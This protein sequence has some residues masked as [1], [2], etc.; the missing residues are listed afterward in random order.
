MGIPLLTPP[1]KY[2]INI[3]WS[4]AI[5]VKSSTVERMDLRV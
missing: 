3:P 4:H 5:D 1:P 2:V